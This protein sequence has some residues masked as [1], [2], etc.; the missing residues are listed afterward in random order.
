MALRLL[1]KAL[2][3]SQ[4]LRYTPREVV[5]AFALLS[6]LVFILSTASSSLFGVRVWF[7]GEEIS[8]FPEQ[9][10]S[11]AFSDMLTYVFSVLLTSLFVTYWARTLGG[12]TKSASNFRFIFLSSV[13]YALSFGI[14]SVPALMFGLRGVLAILS[15][16]LFVDATHL[17]LPA[18]LANKWSAVLQM[19]CI[20]VF[21]TAA[22]GAGWSFLGM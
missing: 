21:T 20:A 22:V 19:L 12:S 15:L 14:P 5:L 9:A 11:R 17:F 7:T 3:K 13:P 1:S 10:L 2:H 8:V 6:S 18:A 4:I 16:G